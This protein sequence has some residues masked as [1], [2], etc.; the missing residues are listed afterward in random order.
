LALLA[1]PAATAWDF[2]VGLEGGAAL[3]FLGSS[4]RSAE[5]S[6]LGGLLLE[7]R[8]LLPRIELE[9][10]ED[11]ES[12]T[13]YGDRLSGGVPWEGGGSYVPVDLG[14]RLSLVAGHFRPF[15]GPFV[16]GAFVLSRNEN[17]SGTNGDVPEWLGLGASVGC[18]LLIPPHP[19]RISVEARGYSSLQSIIET[20][21]YTG[22]AAVELL[23]AVR[24]NVNGP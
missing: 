3:S 22:A 9:A 23:V 15:A 13:Y 18:D 1:S 5:L 21:P 2:G 24:L 6:P 16:R 10:W 14:A 7:E 12:P 11:A 20:G 4:P 19:W 17:L 8:F